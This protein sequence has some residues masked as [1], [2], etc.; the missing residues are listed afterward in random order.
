M[1][2]RRE[3]MR[4]ITN[5]NAP[6]VIYAGTSGFV[7]N[8]ES[9]QLDVVRAIYDEHH[10]WLLG[11]LRKKL[12]C[13]HNAAD[14]AHDIFTRVLIKRESLHFRE[15]KALLITIGR[16]L[17]VD[18][19]RR[20]RLEQAYLEALANLP[21]PETPSPEARTLLLEMLAE[22]DRLLYKL[23]PKVRRAFLLSQIDGLSYVQIATEL[24]VSV[25]SV[26][27]YMTRAYR[28]CYAARYAP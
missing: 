28:S 22:V 8:A 5:R 24:G 12:G 7:M 10:S 9:G 19:F 6:V 2:A 4:I 18:H 25:S 16:G 27:Q 13:P 23:P 17:V 3:R 20:A 14:L 11:W 26:Q 21:A 15:A 1:P